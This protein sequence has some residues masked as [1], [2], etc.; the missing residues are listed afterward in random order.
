MIMKYLILGGARS[1]KS[2]YA[3][4]LAIELHT[5]RAK[6]SGGAQLYYLATYPNVEDDAQML[7]RIQ[8]HK[9]RRDE[10]WINVEETLNIGQFLQNLDKNS[11]ILI[12]CLTLWISNLMFEE[13]DVTQEIDQLCEHINQCPANVILVSNEVGMGLVPETSIGRDFRDFQ[14]IA[15]Q[16]TAQSVDKVALIVAGLPIWA[17]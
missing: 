5:K 8:T 7:S 2:I 13:S 1:G 6:N 9:Q 10:V 16:M 17:K 3:E 15:N 11:T 14:G 4:N 12:D